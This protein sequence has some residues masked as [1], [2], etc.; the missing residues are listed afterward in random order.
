[1]DRCEKKGDDSS[2]GVLAFSLLTSCDTNSIAVKLRS[3][4]ITV[5]AVMIRIKVTTSPAAPSTQRIEQLIFHLVREMYL[6]D[7]PTVSGTY[8]L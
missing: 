6:N 8:P 5:V 1:M 3:K 2:G 7:F 4:S